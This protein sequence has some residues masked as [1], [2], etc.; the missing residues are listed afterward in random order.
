MNSIELKTLIKESLQEVLAEGKNQ[1]PTKEEMM[2]F[3]QQQF[4]RYGE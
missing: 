2:H 4:G 1:D 3:L